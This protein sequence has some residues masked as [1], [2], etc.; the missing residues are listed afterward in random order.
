MHRI[1]AAMEQ[2]RREPPASLGGLAVESV[3]DLQLAVATA[4]GRPAVMVYTLVEP[5]LRAFGHQRHDVLLAV[6]QAALV[7]QNGVGYDSFMQKLEDAAPSSH[8]IVVTVAD[9]LASRITHHLR[10]EEGRMVVA[11]ERGDV[12]DHPAPGGEH[13]SRRGLRLCKVRCRK[14]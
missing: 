5:G 3:D 7:I 9:V 11:G 14:V 10:A 12:D 13:R 1:T 2:L 4:R 8:R 6:A